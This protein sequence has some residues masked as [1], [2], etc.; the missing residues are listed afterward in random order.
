[1]KILQCIQN[2]VFVHFNDVIRI[3]HCALNI[4][5]TKPVAVLKFE[6]TL[7]VKKSKNKMLF[8]FVVI[9]IHSLKDA[10]SNIIIILHNMKTDQCCGGGDI[11]YAVIIKGNSTASRYILSSLKR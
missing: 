8:Y 4:E 11:S 3:A 9:K 10:D 1:M 6:L 5:S 7:F 2:G